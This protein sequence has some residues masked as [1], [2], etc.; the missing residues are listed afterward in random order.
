MKDHN[1]NQK[2]KI[3]NELERGFVITVKSVL[4]TVKTFEL[5]TY[6][7]ALKKDG[8]KIKKENDKRW[9]QYYIA[10]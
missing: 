4:N 3:R 10:K 2:Q 8:L 1:P 7:A 9:K 6:I 5:R